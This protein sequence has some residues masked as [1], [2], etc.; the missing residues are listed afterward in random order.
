MWK[1]IENCARN[2]CLFLCTYYLVLF[3]VTWVFWKMYNLVFSSNF[4]FGPVFGNST[5]WICRNLE[6]FAWVLVFWVLSYIAEVLP[7][8]PEFWGFFYFNFE[9]YH[10]LQIRRTWSIFVSISNIFVNPSSNFAKT[11]SF[12]L[13]LLIFFLSFEFFPP[14]VFL[15]MSKL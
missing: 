10:F 6:F 14:W 12:L 3:E 9:F 2:L 1:G 5:K 7:F 8:L 4:K 15:K 11:L 13:E